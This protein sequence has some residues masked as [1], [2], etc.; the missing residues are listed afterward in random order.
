MN[1]GYTEWNGWSPCSVTCGRGIKK[2]QRFCT[3]PEPAYGGVACGHLGSGEEIV[4][5]Y[6]VNCP[7]ECLLDYMS[8]SSQR[9]LARLTD[10]L[11]SSS[12]STVF[13]LLYVVDGKYSP[14]SQWSACSKTCGY[15]IQTRKRT[16]T[17]PEPQHGGRD[18]TDLG[19]PEHIRPCQV[20]QCPSK[21]QYDYTLRVICKDLENENKK[22]K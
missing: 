12:L 8:N 11:N 21:L 19:D 16:C 22:M 18:C 15:G 4:Q 7:G 9:R 13:H 2:R 3:N 6:D 14:W 5:C 1:G 10:K 17:D 20:I